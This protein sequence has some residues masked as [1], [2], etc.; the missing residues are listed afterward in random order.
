LNGGLPKSAST[1]FCNPI[2]L[3]KRT[4]KFIKELAKF[5]TIIMSM[6]NTAYKAKR[7][8]KNPLEGLILELSSGFVC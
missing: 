8:I 3:P 5:I 1:L 4:S 7:N 6:T 2:C